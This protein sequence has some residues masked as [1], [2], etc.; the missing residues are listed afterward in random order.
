MPRK[1][2]ELKP[3]KR[4]SAGKFLK[5]TSGNPDG[6]INHPFRAAVARAIAQDSATRLRAC[7]ERL[8]DLAAAGEAWAVKELADR[9]DGKAHQSVSA[10]MSGSLTVEIVRLANPAPR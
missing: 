8:L 7:A 3:V 4:N 2:K 9:L 5:G 10:D 1:I 6:P